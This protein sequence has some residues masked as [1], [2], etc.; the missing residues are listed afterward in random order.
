MKIKKEDLVIITK[1]KDRGKKGK[2]I[3]AL[4]KENK[5]V[6]EGLNLVKKHLKPRKRGE[7]GQVILIPRAISV[8]NVKLICPKCNQ[9]SRIGYLFSDDSKSRICKKCQAV[10]D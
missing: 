4:P 3:K 9:A 1:G 5:I 7:K 6:V 8:A 2:I 10:I